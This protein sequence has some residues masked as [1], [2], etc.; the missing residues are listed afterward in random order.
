MQLKKYRKVGVNYEVYK[1]VIFKFNRNDNDTC[2]NANV[3]IDSRG[4]R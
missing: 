1:M 3:Y 4:S 2:G